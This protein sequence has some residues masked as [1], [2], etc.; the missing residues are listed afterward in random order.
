MRGL[1]AHQDLPVLSWKFKGLSV[2]IVSIVNVYVMVTLES[3]LHLRCYS[4][5]FPIDLYQIEF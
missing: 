3:P 4:I 2:V 1:V 5:V